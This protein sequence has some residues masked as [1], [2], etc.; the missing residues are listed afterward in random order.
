MTL[1]RT[2]LPTTLPP[3]E[4][5]QT[6]TTLIETNLT[7]VRLFLVMVQNN[8]FTSTFTLFVPLPQPIRASIPSWTRFSVLGKVQGMSGLIE[9]ARSNLKDHE[10]ILHS[11]E[12]PDEHNQSDKENR[13]DQ[14]NRNAKRQLLVPTKGKRFTWPNVPCSPSRRFTSKPIL[15]FDP[16]DKNDALDATKVYTLLDITGIDVNAQVQHMIEEALKA[17]EEGVRPSTPTHDTMPSSLV[18]AWMV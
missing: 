10:L 6:L 14:V 12:E 2:R 8:H 1:T 16:S 4:A 17:E 5:L 9:A 15:S 7:M 13:P 18:D 11:P 3:T